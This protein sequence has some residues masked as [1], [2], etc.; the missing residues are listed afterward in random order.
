MAVGF[1][2]T[3][4]DTFQSSVNIS[5]YILVSSLKETAHSCFT[6]DNCHSSKS[7]IQPFGCKSCFSHEDLW[8]GSSK[9]GL[10]YQLSS[11]PDK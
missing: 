2:C 8:T 6:S 10:S 4:S 1:L 11:E 5:K 7:V 9:Q 3:L